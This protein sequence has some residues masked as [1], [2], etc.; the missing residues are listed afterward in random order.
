MLFFLSFVSLC[1]VAVCVVLYLCRE[2]ILPF[3]PPSIRS[4]VQYYAPLPSWEAAA[5]AGF[6]TANFSLDQNLAGDERSGLDQ[7]GLTAV[8]RLMDRHSIGFDEARLLRQQQIFRANGIDPITGL[9]MD[10]KAITRL[11]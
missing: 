6:S 3:L 9:P 2:R 11:S 10:S 5:E 4:R 1:L 7:E 8:R